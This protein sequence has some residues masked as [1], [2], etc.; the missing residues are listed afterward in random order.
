MDS[1]PLIPLLKLDGVICPITVGT[2]WRR[3]VSKVAAQSEVRDICMCL[4]DFQFG[5]GVPY[6]REVILH[7]VNR[8]IQENGNFSFMSMLLVD[9]CNDFNMVNRYAMLT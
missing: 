3:L 4:Q 6:R 9:F 2:V 5:V 8:L 7:S 1:A